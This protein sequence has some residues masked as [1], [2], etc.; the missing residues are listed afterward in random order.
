MNTIV[1]I[2]IRYQMVY[3]FRRFIY[4]I[5][6][7]ADFTKC[8]L[9]FDTEGVRISS[10]DD[11]AVGPTSGPPLLSLPPLVPG[12]WAGSAA[13]VECASVKLD[14]VYIYVNPYPRNSSNRT[15][16][17]QSSV[18]HMYHAYRFDLVLPKI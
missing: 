12:A 1:D 9:L 15:I 6:S 16:R 18:H 11:R 8:I 14:F 7:Y 10:A 2:W 13:M 4:Y 3:L 5:A 17:S